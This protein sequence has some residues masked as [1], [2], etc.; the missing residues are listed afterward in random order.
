MIICIGA[1]IVARYI[2]SEPPAWTEE[3]ARYAMIW[4]GLTGATVAYSRREDPVLVKLA[5]L[6]SQW[7]RVAAQYVEVVAVTVFCGTILWASPLFLT[8][9]SQRLSESLEI[10]SV[11]VVSI[12]PISVTV[13][14]YHAFVRLLILI[15]E[16]TN[17]LP[18]P[19]S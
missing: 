17:I 10:P 14:L 13:I 8:L 4:S 9:H 15:F 16:K 3:L 6:P 19:A 5:S 2:F 7:M 18:E 1:Q 11:L 12:I